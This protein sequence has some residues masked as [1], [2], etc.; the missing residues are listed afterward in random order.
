LVV[1]K[2]ERSEQRWE[3]GDGDRR[4]PDFELGQV[5]RPERVA[6]AR[7]LDRPASGLEIEA[8]ARRPGD[9]ARVEWTGKP[10]AENIGEP[11]VDV[12]LVLGHRL[13]PARG[14]RDARSVEEHVAREPVDF[15]LDANGDAPFSKGRIRELDAD[16]DF[17]EIDVVS[18]RGDF[19]D[20]HRAVRTD[21]E[22]ERFRGKRS[23]DADERLVASKR[24]GRVEGERRIG[25]ELERLL[26]RV[27]V[28]FLRH[29]DANFLSLRSER[30]R[31][32]HVLGEGG[33]GELEFGRRTRRRPTDTVGHRAR[34]E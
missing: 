31:A 23:F 21:C 8:W 7:G 4:R 14:E 1:P 2:I 17:V 30:A 11:A 20:S 16:L 25:T 3:L 33:L 22:L 18:R 13:E 19:D 28:L 29:D 10:L 6:S 32:A 12:D 5:T 9:E 34:R 26:R 15:G 24:P 27:V